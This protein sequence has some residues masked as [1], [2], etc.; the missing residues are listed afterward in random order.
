MSDEHW[1]AYYTDLQAY[2]QYQYN[3]TGHRWVLLKLYNT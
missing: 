1:Q 3:S 2:T